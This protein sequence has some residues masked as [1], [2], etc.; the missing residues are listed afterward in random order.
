[1]TC[2]TGLSG[3]AD[4]SLQ[5][6]QA[7]AGKT[8]WTG[9]QTITSHSHLRQAPLVLQ[10]LIS[11]LWEEATSPKERTVGEHA[12]SF[13]SFFLLFLILFF[14]F[15]E[16]VYISLSTAYIR[17][18]WQ[19]YPTSNDRLACVSHFVALPLYK[20]FSWS[21]SSCLKNRLHQGC[22][23]V[24]P[25]LAAGQDLPRLNV[26]NHVALCAHADSSS[27]QVEVDLLL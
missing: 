21:C 27:H 4:A 26:L 7:Q 22:D 15:K 24:L 17:E 6:L 12:N 3:P 9:L 1:M 23:V 25:R 8:P 16:N 19:F 18:K 14:F 20:Q 2:L 13:F 11:G 10:M 5:R